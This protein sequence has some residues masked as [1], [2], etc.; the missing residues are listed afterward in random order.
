MVPPR[1]HISSNS[2]TKRNHKFGRRGI[3]TFSFSKLQ[4]FNQRCS[5]NN[6]NRKFDATCKAS[7][8]I[9]NPFINGTSVYLKQKYLFL[10]FFFCFSLDFHHFNRF[11]MWCIVGDDDDD[12]DD[13]VLYEWCMVGTA[14]K[15]TTIIKIMNINMRHII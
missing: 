12:V 15:A 2:T 3:V 5:Y 11:P 14:A 13:G 8:Y 6:T 4:K 10:K 7:Q 1:R 9:G